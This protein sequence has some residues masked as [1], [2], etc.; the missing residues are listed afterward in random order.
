MPNTNQRTS[1]AR[2]YRVL[3]DGMEPYSPYDITVAAEPAEAHAEFIRSLGHEAAVEERT[4]T[5]TYGPWRT[6]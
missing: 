1:T 3:I 4:V 5:V 2:E 6:R